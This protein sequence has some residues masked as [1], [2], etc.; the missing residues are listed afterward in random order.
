[1]RCARGSSTTTEADDSEGGPPDDGARRSDD[2]GRR[3]RV[4]GGIVPTAGEQRLEQHTNE[5]VEERYRHCSPSAHEW[6]E[7]DYEPWSE[8]GFRVSTPFRSVRSSRSGINSSTITPSGS[9]PRLSW[10]A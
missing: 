6:T 3:S 1:M 4:L 2:G 8:R 7:E 5:H 10:Q 9:F